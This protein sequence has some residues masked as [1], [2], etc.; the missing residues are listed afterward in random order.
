MPRTKNKVSKDDRPKLDELRRTYRDGGVPVSALHVAMHMLAVREKQ[1]YL[2]VPT[3]H[4]V[5]LWLRQPGHEKSA[6]NHP[7][8]E[9]LAL[10]WDA[11][12]MRKAEK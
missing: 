3:A 6:G 1:K 8:P 9:M 7:S 12:N 11:H 4:Q 2:R 5:R 10:M